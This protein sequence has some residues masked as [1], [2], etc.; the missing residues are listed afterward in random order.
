MANIAQVVNV[1]A[2]IHAEEKGLYLHTIYYAL[3][4]F[5]QHMHGTALD[6]LV[7]C[8][9]LRQPDSTRFPI[10]MS[11]PPIARIRSRW[12]WGGQSP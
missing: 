11:A 3:Q 5:A 7:K 1:L 8:G 6:T 9:R 12:F 2:P 4:L 10:S